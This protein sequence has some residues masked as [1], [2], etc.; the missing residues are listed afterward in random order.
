MSAAVAKALKP[1]S[2]C[3]PRFW[4]MLTLPAIEASAARLS[5]VFTLAFPLFVKESEPVKSGSLSA[6]KAVSAALPEIEIEADEADDCL[7]DVNSDRS[8]DLS[9]RLLE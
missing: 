5:T 1:S 9:S 8:T 7:I 2:V 3:R 6:L 4:V